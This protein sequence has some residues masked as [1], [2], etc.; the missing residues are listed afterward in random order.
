VAYS[1]AGAPIAVTILLGLSA[2]VFWHTPPIGPVGLV[3]FAAAVVLGARR[4]PAGRPSE[5]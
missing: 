2:L 4:W 5:E 1:R 3:C